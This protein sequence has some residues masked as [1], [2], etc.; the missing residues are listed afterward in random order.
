LNRRIIAF[1]RDEENHWVARLACGHSRHVRH[2]PPWQS[3]P[4]VETVEGRQAKIG[5]ILNCKKCDYGD[6]SEAAPGK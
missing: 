6:P 1:Y 2:D 3:R 5:Q 4:W